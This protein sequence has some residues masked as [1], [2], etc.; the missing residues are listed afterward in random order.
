MKQTEQELKD[1]Q[2]QYYEKHSTRVKPD[3]TLKIKRD[4]D[5]KDLSFISRLNIKKLYISRCVNISFENMTSQ[6]CEEMSVN[7][8]QLKSILGISNLNKL[9]YLDLTFNKIKNLDQLSNLNFLNTLSVQHNEIIDLSPLSHLTRLQ[10][11]YSSNNNI[12]D[13]HSIRNL[14]QLIVIFLCQNKITDLNGVQQLKKLKELYLQDNIITDISPLS[15][16]SSLTQLQLQNNQITDISPLQNDKLKYLSI[17]QNYVTSFQTLNKL[18][19][20]IKIGNQK[21]PNPLQILISKRMKS[22]FTTRLHLESIKQKHQ[23]LTNL[24]SSSL[25]KTISQM[26][27]LTIDQ[28]NLSNHLLIVFG[29]AEQASQ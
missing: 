24:Y 19:R 23:F 11:L 10:Y 22:I 1:I 8:C 29:T 9:T 12:T 7:Y 20:T 6:S 26:N 18:E 5:L 25:S 2:N 14:R 17:E 4:Q 13:L 15:E 16:C 27:S 21:V 28:L 3:G